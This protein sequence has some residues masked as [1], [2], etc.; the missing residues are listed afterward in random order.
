MTR[1]RPSR[2][3]ESGGTFLQA[4]SGTCLRQCSKLPNGC[5]DSYGVCGATQSPISSCGRGLFNPE[6]LDQGY[7]AVLQGNDIKFQRYCKDIERHHGGILPQRGAVPCLIKVIFSS[8]VVRMTSAYFQ[9]LWH[10]VT[11]C[12]TSVLP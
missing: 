4:G 6:Q 10:D 2:T 7:Q 5:V 3:S 8:L 12:V 11:Q 9:L 1:S